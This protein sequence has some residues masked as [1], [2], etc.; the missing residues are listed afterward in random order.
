MDL[1]TF[2]E[3][4]LVNGASQASAKSHCDKVASFFRQY[5]E[6][7]QENLNSY[8]AS[9]L[10]KWV[11]N[12]F[13]ININAFTHYAKFL[14][15]EIEIPK[16]HKTEK[17]IMEYISEKD[18]YDILEKTPLIFDN[19]DKVQAILILLFSTGLRPKEIV[20]LKR[21][22]F[23]FE[24]KEIL[25]SNT[26]THRDRAVAM[27]NVLCNMLPAIFSQQ[28]EE[29]NAFNIQHHHLTY[30][31]QKLNEVM[32]LKVK[33]TPYSMRRSYC[34]NLISKGV[35]LTSLQR[36]LGHS[37]IATTLRYIDVSNADAMEEIRTILNK[38]R[39]R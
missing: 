6:F 2:K 19:S 34:H 38:R 24:S 1:T 26:K 11:G 18:F 32:G 3:W 15:M 21:E 13:N 8:L 17:R 37:Q 35:K 12:S 7:N 4:M 16:Y 22:N 5:Q 33:L 14:K 30:I 23:N 31:F 25:I 36:S 9:K 27:S 29:I 39:K 28:A 10:D 20:S